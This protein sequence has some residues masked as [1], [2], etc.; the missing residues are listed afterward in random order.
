MKDGLVGSKT[1]LAGNM[2]KAHG[3]MNVPCL[4][5]LT[6]VLVI[7]G[8]SQIR[9]LVRMITKLQ[10]VRVPEQL[11][12][13]YRKSESVSQGGTYSTA[14]DLARRHSKTDGFDYIFLNRVRV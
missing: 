4:W 12:H 9:R 3:G 14:R 2:R 8:V 13:S 1:E 7:C 6:F 10:N 11:V 5:L